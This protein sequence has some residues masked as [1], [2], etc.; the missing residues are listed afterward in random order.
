MEDRTWNEWSA[1]FKSEGARFDAGAVARRARRSS[2]VMAAETALTVGVCLGVTGL[3]VYKATVKPHPVIIAIC[4]AVIAFLAVSAIA[5]F[6]VRRGAWRAADQTP[7]ALIALLRRREVS[8]LREARFSMKSSIALGV[9]VTLWIPWRLW[10]DWEGYVREPWR[11]AI[12][13]GGTYALL[14]LALLA[15]R[16]WIRRRERALETVREMARSFENGEESKGGGR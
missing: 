6:R 8:R 14:A 15:T 12:G 10:I 2:L 3:L 9:A 4:A 5:F 1:D 16:R 11:A 7:R 13:V